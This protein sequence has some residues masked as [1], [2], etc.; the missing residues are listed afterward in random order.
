MTKS[1]LSKP[2]Y[3]HDCTDCRFLGQVD[4]YDLYVC[5]T[6]E[7]TGL[8]RYGDR[9]PEYASRG[10]L[11]REIDKVNQETGGLQ[12]DEAVILAIFQAMPSLVLNIWKRATP[13][14][15]KFSANSIVDDCNICGDRFA[16]HR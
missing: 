10:F 5:H 2:R 3:T 7:I 14:P 15:H 4:K 1:P 9:G 11:R 6:D 8:A 12:G 13:R 16:A